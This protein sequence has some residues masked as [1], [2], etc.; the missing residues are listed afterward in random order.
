MKKVVF[1]LLAASLAAYAASISGKV[2]AGK[3][4]SVVYV[5]AV[6][7]KTFPAPAKP[8]VMDQNH[9]RVSE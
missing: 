9:G 4:T 6:A 1:V 7:G 2:V 3:G 8:Q 5:D